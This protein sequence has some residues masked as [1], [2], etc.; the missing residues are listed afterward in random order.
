MRFRGLLGP[1]VVVGLFG[2]ASVWSPF[3]PHRPPEPNAPAR[4]AQPLMGSA[5]TAA[6]ESGGSA[7]VSGAHEASSAWSPE[8]RRDFQEVVNGALAAGADTLRFG[9]AIV[10]VGRS[11][12]GTAYVPGT[13]EAEGPERVI[14]NFRGLDCVTYVETVWALTRL[15][16][17]Q[18]QLH[19]SNP[20]DAEQLYEQFLAEIRY[21]D[22]VVSYPTRLH[23]F[24]DWIRHGDDR[25]LLADLTEELG[26]V[27]DPEPID[28]MS[29]HPESYRQLRDETFLAQVEEREAYLSTSGRHYIPEGS[30]AA[31]A[32]RIRDGDVIAAT[33]TVRGL[34]V[35]H[36]GIA[37]WVEGELHLMHA[38]LVGSEVQISE[39]PLA[40]R[41]AAIDGQD[42]IMVARLTAEGS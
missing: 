15:V 37:V 26:G 39:V 17:Q 36:V 19:L 6:P 30:I 35:A 8:T 38:P 4:P 40:R 22:G 32:P 23:Y 1:I 12:L 20:V 9:E 14:V 11:F 25:G 13:L 28:F 31:V 7:V 5:A 21:R 24:S 34:D 3:E 29:T 33:S 18:P 27:P 2:I 41:I 16:R 10:A 42:G